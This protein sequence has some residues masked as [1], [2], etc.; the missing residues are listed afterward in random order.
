MKE[1]DRTKLPKWAQHEMKTLEM[2]AREADQRAEMFKK[3]SR[4]TIDSNTFIDHYDRP[5]HKLPPFS[6]VSFEVGRGVVNVRIAS[7][8][9]SVRI[10]A[11]SRFAEIMVV[12]PKSSN[13]IELGWVDY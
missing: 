8:G 11:N 4:G 7:D 1:H 10:H 2:F 6:D 13:Y 5:S 9:E 3:L 12:Y